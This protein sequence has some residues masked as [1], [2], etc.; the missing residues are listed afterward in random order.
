MRGAYFA[1]LSQALAAAFAILLIGQQDTTGGSNGLNNF[2]GFFGFD[3]DDPVN[4]QMLYFIAAGALLVM[5]AVA[6]QLMR[7]PLRRAAGR[8]PRLRGAG[9]LPRLRP[10]QRQDS[11][12]TWWPR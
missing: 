4:K 5:L 12:P 3:L 6:R 9:P 7:Q 10:G 8:L 1:I 11:S 2:K